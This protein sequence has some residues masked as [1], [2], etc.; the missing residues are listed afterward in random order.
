[1]DRQIARHSQ[2]GF[3]VVMLDVNDLKLVNDTQGH[4]A[5]DQ[6][7]RDACKIICDTFKHSPVFR[8]GG[9][10]FVVIT[11]GSDYENIEEL[12]Q[13]IHD[14]NVEAAR[15]GTV[16]VACGMSRFQNDDC[17]ATVFERADHHMYADKNALK[18]AT[19]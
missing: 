4:Q 13:T 9:D 17:V 5:G 16:V 7:L 11:Q 19:I 1:M 6:Y 3:A 15:N 14:H 8:V 18:S 12:L 10:E 2:P